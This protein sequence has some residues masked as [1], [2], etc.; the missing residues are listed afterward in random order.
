M[1]KIVFCTLTMTLCILFGLSSIAPAVAWT[2]PGL[3]VTV[4]NPASKPIPVTGKTS[5]LFNYP[6]GVGSLTLP[7]TFTDI[8]VSQCTSF[9]F[10]TWD[11]GPDVT[12]CT[13][14]DAV[15]TTI[16]AKG[17]FGATG[18]NYGGVNLTVT[19]PAVLINIEC[20]GTGGFGAYLYCR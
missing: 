1:K 13:I 4:V 11:D 3:F 17:I 10:V 19:V 15:S 18:T 14:T 12:D 5:I 7:H 8:D 20:N 6:Y 16:L 2:Y 9:R